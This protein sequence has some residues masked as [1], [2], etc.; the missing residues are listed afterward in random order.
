MPAPS[1]TPPSVY[2]AKIDVWVFPGLFLTSVLAVGLPVR[3]F[4][5]TWDGAPIGAGLGL[6]LI[7]ALVAVTWRLRYTITDQD[8]IAK[9]ATFELIVPL[10]AIQGIEPVRSFT[11]EAC[12]S[13][14]RVRI[15]LW[16][17]SIMVAPM[18]RDDFI[19]EL[20]ARWQQHRV[21]S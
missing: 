17:R 12:L 15:A 18:D 8:L 16:H 5:G 6:S 20:T 21:R 10:S 14:Q 9:S 1:A 2:R 11:P 13:T 19:A 4:A 3:A 7:V